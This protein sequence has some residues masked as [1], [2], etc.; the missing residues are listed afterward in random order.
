MRP[1]LFVICFALG[2]TLMIISGY[3][4]KTAS[5][6]NAQLRQ[7]DTPFDHRADSAHPSA[8]APAV[9][10][11][12]PSTPLDAIRSASKAD[13][14][15]RA[16]AIGRDAADAGSAVESP[17][18]GEAVAAD[19]SSSQSRSEDV[20]APAQPSDDSAAS[21]AGSQDMAPDSTPG[22]A[23]PTVSAG[24]GGVVWIGWDDLPLAGS[25]EG[26]G[27]TYLWKQ[28]GGPLTL[29]I[30]DA[31][32]VVA[33]ASGLALHERAGW[34]ADVYK[35]E[36]TVTDAQGRQAVDTV[37]YVVK[38]APELRI[39]PRA[40]RWFELR[41]GYWLGHYEAWVTNLETE[42]S[43]FEIQSASELTFT[44]VAGADYELAAGKANGG[45]AYHVTLYSLGDQATS[46]VEFLVDTAE[47]VPGTV[48][49]G[50]NWEAR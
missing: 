29:T 8:R 21:A 37:R 16:E 40:T 27:L 22:G 31:D 1:V 32:K 5:A 19:A 39:V 48:R 46:W 44:K 4:P 38:P 17:P 47:K 20:A 9:S 23:G 42:Q 45:H 49:L 35:F 41:D 15:P 25:G 43:A 3:L 11:G 2:V 33:A 18:P 34:T 30:R 26:D 36:L 28:V 10:R 13:D 14:T 12:S 6:G 7:R 50:V 24:R